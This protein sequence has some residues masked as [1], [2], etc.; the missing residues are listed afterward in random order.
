MF[1]NQKI[2][3][4]IACKLKKNR[5]NGTPDIASRKAFER[6]P[7]DFKEKLVRQKKRA[8]VKHK[9]VWGNN[10]PADRNIV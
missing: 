10:L 9:I 2:F 3:S 7:E 8:G 1:Y 4:F 6:S 5:L